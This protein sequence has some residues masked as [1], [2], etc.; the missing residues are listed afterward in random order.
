VSG[1]LHDIVNFLTS[2]TTAV[3]E[4]APVRESTSARS[5]CRAQSLWVC[6]ARDRDRLYRVR[7][8][9]RPLLRGLGATG[10]RATS[11]IVLLRIRRARAT[12]ALSRAP[13]RLLCAACRACAARFVIVLASNCGQRRARGDFVYGFPGARRLGGRNRESRRAGM[14]CRGSSSRYGARKQKRRR[15]EACGDAADACASAGRSSYA[16]WRSYASFLVADFVCARI[17]DAGARGR[18]SRALQSSSSCALVLRRC[19]LD[20]G[21]GDRGAQPPRGN[22]CSARRAD[23]AYAARCG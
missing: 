20:R 2:A 5:G 11:Q 19:V 4:S 15:P 14:G 10:S 17:G 23:G 22:G 3:V 7:G 16:R 13:A 21:E 1:A 12:A 8:A 18:I 6:F 9:R